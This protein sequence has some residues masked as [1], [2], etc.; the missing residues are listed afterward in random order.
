M[1]GALSKAER[2]AQTILLANMRQHFHVTALPAAHRPP[3][4][5]AKATRRD[6][7]DTADHLNLPEMPPL[8]DKREP[9]DFWLAKNAVAFFNISLSSFKIRFSS[10]SRSFSLAKS[11]CG[12]IGISV[13]RYTDIHLLPHLYLG[14]DLP[15]P[16]SLATRARGKPLL[17]AS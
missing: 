1:P 16:R 17:T 8:F 12:A 13:G 9:H 4:P 2:K 14:V 11:A 15:T 7:H 10:R 3:Q 6:L 5:F